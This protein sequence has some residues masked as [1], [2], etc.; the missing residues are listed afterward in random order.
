MI[1]LISKLTCLRGHPFE[2]LILLVDGGI[3]R[4]KVFNKGAGADCTVIGRVRTNLVI[5]SI[6]KDTNKILCINT[7]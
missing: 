1:S 6:E 2:N 5:A 7:I 3:L 4:S